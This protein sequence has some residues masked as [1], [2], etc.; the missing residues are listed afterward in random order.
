MSEI[1]SINDFSMQFGDVSVINKLSFAVKEGETFG[2]LGSNGSGKTTT[3]RAL[4]G[5]YPPTS[6]SLL[7]GGAPY[8]V[9]G[10]VKLGYL[11][12]R[13]SVV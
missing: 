9:A 11:P 5:I 7:V 2:L 10:G 12:D 8:S 4:L 13:K 6:G 1:I 3:I